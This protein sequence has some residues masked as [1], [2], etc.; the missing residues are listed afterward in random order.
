M[1]F[2]VL[3]PSSSGVAAKIVDLAGPVDPVVS[4]SIRGYQVTGYH[5]QPQESLECGP[6]FGGCFVDE[7]LGEE[8]TR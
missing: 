3:L 8:P 4:F 5:F 7:T 2:S 1:A 6:Q